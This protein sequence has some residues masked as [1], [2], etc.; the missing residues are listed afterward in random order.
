MSDTSGIQWLSRTRWANKNRW[1]SAGTT[2]L[3]G[4]HWQTGSA[5]VHQH[6]PVAATVQWWPAA[7]ASELSTSG[8]R[9]RVNRSIPGPGPVPI[10]TPPWRPGTA[11][12]PPRLR[13]PSPTPRRDH[14]R[15]R[16]NSAAQLER[17]ALNDLSCINWKAKG[18]AGNKLQ[19]EL[20]LE[21]GVPGARRISE[22][23]TATWEGSCIYNTSNWDEDGEQRPETWTRGNNGAAGTWEG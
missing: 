14:I 13:P 22:S 11:P 18:L 8:V 4:Q 12:V 3:I 16:C 2:D 17:I 23:Y 5:N 9:V 1:R 10:P 7:A 15:R 6:P 20:D 21:E 19:V